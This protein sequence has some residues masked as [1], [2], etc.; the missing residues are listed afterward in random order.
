MTGMATKRMGGEFPPPYTADREESWRRAGPSA[1]RLLDSGSVVNPS[2]TI[3]GHPSP[4]PVHQ[5][6]DLPPQPVPSSSEAS[7][8][9]SRTQNPKGFFPAAQHHEREYSPYG[10]STCEGHLYSSPRHKEDSRCLLQSHASVRERLLLVAKDDGKCLTNAA[11]HPHATSTNPPT[12][13]L[14]L[15]MG[16]PMTCYALTQ[17]FDVL[18]PIHRW[19]RHTR[20]RAATALR[21]TRPTFSKPR[22]ND[23]DGLGHTPRHPR[24][25]D[26]ISTPF[27]LDQLAYS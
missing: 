21:L 16:S 19:Q 5:A 1:Q 3:D 8:R 14:S 25:A 7:T 11:A 24:S 13:R 15:K 22:D 26:T 9:E 12:P 23:G 6:I 27:R 20:Q 10:S 4:P 2:S 17:E 18:D